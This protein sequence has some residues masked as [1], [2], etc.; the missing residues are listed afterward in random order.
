MP[1]LVVTAKQVDRG[2]AILDTV[3]GRAEQSSGIG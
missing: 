2:L 3:I 1:T